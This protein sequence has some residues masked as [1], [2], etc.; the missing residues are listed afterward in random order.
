MTPMNLIDVPV[1]D[2]GRRLERVLVKIND[3]R[4]KSKT[5]GLYF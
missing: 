2:Q 1:Y 4:W 5:A 3:K